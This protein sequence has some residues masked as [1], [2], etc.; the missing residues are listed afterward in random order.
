MGIC[1]ASADAIM[2]GARTV[3]D[4]SPEGLWIPEYTYPEAKHLYSDYRVNV[5]SKPRYPIVV[6]VS[7]SGRLEL[8]RAVFR[9][10]GVRTVIITTPA[11]KDE[12]AKVGGRK[13]DSVEICVVDATGDSFAPHELLRLLHV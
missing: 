5:L 9:A 6:I 3:H 13:L 12:L 8:E 1:I 4:V 7:G 11:G 2:V 10:T